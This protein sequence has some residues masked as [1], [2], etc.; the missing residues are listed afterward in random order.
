MKALYQVVVG[1]LK[2]LQ[3]GC[4][5]GRGSWTLRPRLSSSFFLSLCVEGSLFVATS[6]EGHWWHSP[7]IANA[8]SIIN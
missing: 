5:L 7:L 1:I 2:A 3:A 8:Y 4:S 6:S